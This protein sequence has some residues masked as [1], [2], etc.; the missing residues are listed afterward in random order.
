MPWKDVRPMDEK[1]LFIADHLREQGS[2]S[3]L[4]DRYGISRKTGYKWVQRYQE[5]G[6]EGLGERSRR[7]LYSGETPFAVREAILALRNELRDPPGPKKIQALL[8]GRID[9]EAIPSKTTIYNILKRAGQVETRRRRRR[10]HRAVHPLQAAQAPNELWSADYKGQF[11]LRN[12]KWC[13]PLT[14][15]DHASRYLLVCKGLTATRFSD[16]QGIFIRLFQ[17]YG[18]PERIRTDNGVPFAS[19]GVAGLSSL[20]IWW[21]RLGIHPE[22][23][24]PGQ[25]QQNG[26]HERMHR[27]LKRAIQ[28]ALAPHLRGQQAI[29]DDFRTQY[30]EQRP[31]EGLQQQ[32]PQSCYQPSPRPYPKVLPHPEY[33][34]YF[35]RHRVCQNGLIYWR[36]KRVYAGYLLAG[37]WVGLEPVGDGLWDVYFGPIRL[38]GFDVRNAEGPRKDY[39]NCHPCR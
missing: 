34:G 32:P 35:D 21:I 30:N 16:A 33:P 29:F 10:V 19:T 17:E 1:V 27:T 9:A 2:F 5:A 7:P 15:M 37:N 12:G 6:V 20:S 31:H 22:R 24:A 3:E 18:L 26:R 13:Y 8:A 36:G 4:C 11:K 23:I 28:A 39:L 25:P 14:V 38:G